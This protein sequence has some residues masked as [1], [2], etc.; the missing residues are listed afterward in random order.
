MLPVWVRWSGGV[1]RSSLNHRLMAWMPP[2]SARVCGP[3]KAHADPLNHGL[4]AWMPPAS[5]RACG[6]RKAHADPLNHRLMPLMPPAS[7]RA[8][9][10]RKAHADP[11]NHRLMAWMPPAS[12]CAWDPRKVHADPLNHRL[13]AWM[14]PPSNDLEN[15]AIISGKETRSMR[16]DRGRVRSISISREQ[17]DP[18]RKHPPPQARRGRRWPLPFPRK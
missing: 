8:F 7:A 5:A 11:L 4:M 16:G 10:P 2:A 14:P 18:C 13:M 15:V 12:A 1:A 9:G 17:Q 3:R 6:L